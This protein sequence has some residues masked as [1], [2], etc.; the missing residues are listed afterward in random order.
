MFYLLFLETSRNVSFIILMY[1]VTNRTTEQILARISVICFFG[2]PLA[3]PEAVKH[4]MLPRRLNHHQ[5]CF[6]QIMLMYYFAAVNTFE[7]SPGLPF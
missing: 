3:A 4:W 6:L 2:H 7:M 5:P 1:R